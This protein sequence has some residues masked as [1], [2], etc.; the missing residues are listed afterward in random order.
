MIVKFESVTAQQLLAL[1]QLIKSKNNTFEKKWS[2]E[3]DGDGLPYKQQRRCTIAA[4][5]LLK[6]SSESFETSSGI[7]IKFNITL[8]IKEKL[9]DKK[10]VSRVKIFTRKL[11]TSHNRQ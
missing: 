9:Y 5:K 1:E 4:I 2:V 8:E 11:F 10:I 6:T 7:E 3:K